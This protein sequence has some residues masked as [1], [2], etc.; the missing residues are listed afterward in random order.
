MKCEY[1]HHKEK[2]H[3]INVS[4]KESDGQIK[5]IISIDGQLSLENQDRKLAGV[6]AALWAQLQW[7]QDVSAQECCNQV[8]TARI[9]KPQSIA[10]CYYQLCLCFLLF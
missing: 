10:L 7:Q 9:D 5:E 2:N 4:E 1:F 3:S 8:P 6:T